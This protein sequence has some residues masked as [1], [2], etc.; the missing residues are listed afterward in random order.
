MRRAPVGG[1]GNPHRVGVLAGSF[2]PPTVAHLHLLDAARPMVDE[3]LCVLPRAFP[4]KQYHGASLGERV[5]MLEEAG[6]GAGFSIAIAEGGLLAEIAEECRAAFEAPVRL[7]FLCGRDAAERIVEWDYG[8]RG[9]IDE[10]LESFE[11][12]VAPRG[13]AYRPPEHLKHRVH[14]LET[15][16]RFDG[17]SSSELRERIARGRGWEELTPEALREAV[18]RIYR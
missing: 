16:E 13:G 5:G 17:V 15:D 12:L 7:F 1:M 6:G 11:L 3:L 18:R 4:H 2:N 10:M 9:A 8:R 14:H